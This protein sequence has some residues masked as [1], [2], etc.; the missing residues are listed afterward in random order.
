MY[1]RALRLT[2]GVIAL[3]AIGAAT[4]L[5]IRSEQHINQQTASLRVFD[6]QARDA[7]AALVDARVS[8][9]AYVAA[10]QGVEFWFNK[11]AGSLQSA[12][13]G[14]TALR[15]AAGAAAGTSVDQ[16]AATVEE[17]STLDKRA[18]DYLG[19]G[20]QLMAGDV[21]F[22]EGSDAAATACTP[23]RNRPAGAAPGR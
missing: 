17:F 5:L 16:A 19:S 8:Q 3:I 18:R 4:I 22:T 23:D 7:T 6:Q 9:Q 2:C 12:K 21:I 15:L 20:D 11:T 1:S 14:L 10:G 13:D